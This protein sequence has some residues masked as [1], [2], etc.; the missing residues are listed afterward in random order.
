MVRGTLEIGR[1]PRF[2]V[3]R[4]NSVAVER[5]DHK[6][7]PCS[8]ELVGLRGGAGGGLMLKKRTAE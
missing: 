1:A 6:A 3:H 5:T 8:S 7:L 2:A 4:A